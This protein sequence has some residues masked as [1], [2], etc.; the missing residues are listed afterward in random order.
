MTQGRRQWK[1]G[2]ENDLKMP[3]L[4][5]GMMQPQAKN[6]G[7]HQKLEEARNIFSPKDSRATVALLI[8]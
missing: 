3:A 7:S 1:G 6:S 8:P 4:K 5:K 2:A